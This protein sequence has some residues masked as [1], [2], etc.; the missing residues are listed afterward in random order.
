MENLSVLCRKYLG[1]EK[2][3]IDVGIASA[4]VRDNVFEVKVGS[5]GVSGRAHKGDDI[6][7]KNLLTNGNEDV[8][9]MA[10]SG[11]S[12]R[13]LMINQDLIAV[14]VAVIS[15]LDDESVEK[16]WDRGSVFIAEIHAGMEGV[17]AVDR[18]VSPPKPGCDRKIVDAGAGCIHN[19]K[20]KESEK[21]FLQRYDLLSRLILGKRNLI[22]Y[23]KLI[24]NGQTYL[25]AGL[26]G[27]I[28]DMRRIS[29]IVIAKLGNKG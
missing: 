16:S 13:I 22:Q 28:A 23:F 3:R 17:F 19:K 25:P 21:D 27:F 15:G 2:E 4:A 10:V 20:K 11:E 26:Y 29:V 14:S 18:M 8:R 1:P 9:A 24:S 7:R 6:I 5:G 12:I